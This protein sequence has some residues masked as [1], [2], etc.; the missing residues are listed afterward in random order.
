[1][2]LVVGLGNPGRKYEHTRHN[3][4]FTVLNE[5]ARR[6]N[7]GPP[8]TNFQGVVAEFLLRGQR[9][10]L[11]WPHTFMNLSG[12]SALAARDFYKIEDAD[13]LVVC[14]DFNLPLGK[15]RLRAEGSAGGQKGLADV[16]VRFGSDKVPRL[17]IGVGPVPTNRDPADF[18]LS[19]FSTD[20]LPEIEM[21][22]AR[23]ADAIEDWA[24]TTIGECMNKY[25]A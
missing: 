4:G 22:V 20:E 11:L 15:L 25:N 1:V 7:A 14:D 2:K 16:L 6:Q 17:R 24:A 3:V 10:L 8:K 5:I 21:T 18:V 23:A 13:V 9:V 12:A 19:R